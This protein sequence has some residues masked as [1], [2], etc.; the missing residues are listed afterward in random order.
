MPYLFLLFGAW[1][2]TLPARDF[3]LFAPTLFPLSTLAANLA[4]FFD[5]FPDCIGEL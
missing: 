2:S 1:V 5:D 3:A 4:N